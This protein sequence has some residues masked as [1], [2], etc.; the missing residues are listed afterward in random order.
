VQPLH[1]LSDGQR[2]RV[3]FARLAMERP[4]VLVLDEPSNHLDLQS[5][6]ALK[7]ALS[8]FSGAVVRSTAVECTAV[9]T[10]FICSP[11]QRSL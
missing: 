6:D 7:D 5:I 3:A 8:T 4:H 11:C 9:A 10:T 1:T 2:V